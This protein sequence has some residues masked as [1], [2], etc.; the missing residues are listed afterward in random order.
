MI[1]LIASDLDG[2]L[3]NDD[4]KASEKNLA[5]IQKFQDAGY[6]FVAVTGRD[7][8]SVVQ[9]LD[10]ESLGCECIAVSGAEI[11]DKEGNVIS[12]KNFPYELLEQLEALV[13]PFGAHICYYA[14]DGYYTVGDLE[15]RK[16]FLLDEIKIL[17]Y[18]G[19]PEEILNHEVYQK[20]INLLG[21]LED[22]TDLRK[23]NIG[24]SKVFAFHRDPERVKKAREALTAVEDRVSLLSA[25][26]ATIEIIDIDAQKGPVLKKYAADHGYTMDEVAVVGDSPNDLS[27]FA[28]DFGAKIVVE[29]GFGIVKEIA[30]HVTKNNNE[31]GIAYLV[32]KILAGELDDLKK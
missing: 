5:A 29:N 31:D 20:R 3:F 15:Y 12:C 6:E 26:D 23:R 21:L 18:D 11:R 8:P 24:I 28:E 2:T 1:K 9:I 7:Y 16:E 25:F 13:K 32:E 17:F 10:G 4:H 14:E 19:T 30:T 22:I 27:M